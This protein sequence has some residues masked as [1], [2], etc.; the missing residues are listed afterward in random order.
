MHESIR[1]PILY[2]IKTAMEESKEQR[3]IDEL[4]RGFE[5][6]RE[7][8]RLHR[9]LMEGIREREKERQIEIQVEALRRLEE[10][11]KP[12]QEAQPK[13]EANKNDMELSGLLNLPPQRLN[14]WAQV[15]DDMTRDF[16][17]EHGKIPNETQAWGVLWT[18]PPKTYSITTG[19]DRGDD[20][21]FM[22]G[23]NLL[24]KSGFIKRWKGYTK[25]GRISPNKTR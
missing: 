22:P 6:S 19:K 18:N 4:N 12:T 24:S 16:F 7:M 11:R 21:L 8:M 5:R 1:N 3:E 14:G 13:A 15:I 9:D 17:N 23:E 25:K 10:G 20:C 2:A